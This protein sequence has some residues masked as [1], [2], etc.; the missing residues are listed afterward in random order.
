MSTLALVSIIIAAA[1]LLL[2]C[3]PVVRRYLRYR[4]TRL[5][6]CP[7]TKSAAAVEVDAFPAAYSESALKKL[8][9]KEC[10]R[11]PERQN[12]GQE[13]LREI[14]AAPEDC[15]VRNILTRWYEGK[16]CAVCGK[17]VGQ[18]DWLEHKPGVIGSDRRTA[19]WPEFRAENI[20]AIMTTHQPICWDCHVA[21]TFR[22]QFPDL[23]VDRPWKRN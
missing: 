6:S 8:R 16:K 13:C 23:V 4:G 20:P 14:E 19:L 10:S 21:S 18:I 5:V 11:W 22:R 2:V 12:C 17:S 7:E 15:L 3:I 9:L 1:A